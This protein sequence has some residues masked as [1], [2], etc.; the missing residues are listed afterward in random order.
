LL[1]SKWAVGLGA[2][3]DDSYECALEY[4]VNQKDWFYINRE[5]TNNDVDLACREELLS[6]YCILEPDADECSD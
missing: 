2:Y 3:S 5:S 1:K 4:K 6:A